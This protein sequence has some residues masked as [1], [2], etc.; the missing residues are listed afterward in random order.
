MIET[1]GKSNFESVVTGWGEHAVLRTPEWAYIFRWSPGPAFE[2]LYDL[3]N[4]PEELGNVIEKKPN[5]AAHMKE[6][7]RSYIDAGWEITRG[8][9]AKKLS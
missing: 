5:V 9:F 2:Q 3:K 8:T 1:Q 7:L 6:Q 4:D